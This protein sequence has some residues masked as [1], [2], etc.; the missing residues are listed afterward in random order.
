[1]TFLISMNIRGLGVAPKFLALKNIFLSAL[2]KIIFIQETMH[3]STVTL[4]F[5]RKMFPSWHMVAMEATGQSGG[6]AVLWD[7]TWINAKAFKCCVGILISAS[8]RGQSLSINMLNIYAP[9]RD[10]LSFWEKLIDS[11]LLDMESLMIAGDLNVTLE[12]DEVWGA[13]RRND[14]LGERLR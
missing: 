13:G 14:P 4:A 11:E 1:M 3:S 2:L 10:W 7:P 9:C 12:S 6:L 5:F 8:T